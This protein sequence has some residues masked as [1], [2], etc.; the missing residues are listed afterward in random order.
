[1]LFKACQCV[2]HHGGVATLMQVVAAGKP[3][4]ILPRTLDQF[5]QAV[6]A[7]KL[8]VAEVL[9]FKKMSEIELLRGIE[10]V[11]A[12]PKDDRFEK[13][14]SSLLDEHGDLIAY[15]KINQLLHELELKNEDLSKI[16]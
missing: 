12:R 6:R 15:K 2:V 1:M 5:D 9:P 11:L 8:G 13:L 4:L 16:C 7:R 3:S 14:K 10:R